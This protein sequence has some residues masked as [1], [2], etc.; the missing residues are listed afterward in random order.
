M[1]SRHILGSETKF[2]SL[3]IIERGLHVEEPHI[4]VGIKEAAQQSTGARPGKSGSLGDQLGPLSRGGVH[5]QGCSGQVSQA[6]GVSSEIRDFWG[7]GRDGA[8]M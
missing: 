3:V 2:K 7:G 1:D 8:K 4:G 5:S 6:A